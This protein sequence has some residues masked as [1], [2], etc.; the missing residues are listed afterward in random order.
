[1]GKKIFL[2]DFCNRSKISN[3]PI[4]P[5]APNTTDVFF[6]ALFRE[7]TQNFECLDCDQE[8]LRHFEYDNV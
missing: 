3:L 5:E 6:I 2:L 4:K 8:V 7:N 1:M